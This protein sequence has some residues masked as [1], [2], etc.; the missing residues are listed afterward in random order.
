[1]EVDPLGRL[2]G[3]VSYGTLPRVVAIPDGADLMVEWPLVGT[4]KGGLS[5]QCRLFGDR[6][7]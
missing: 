1:M 2:N 3:D 6:M 4:V 7:W 5:G